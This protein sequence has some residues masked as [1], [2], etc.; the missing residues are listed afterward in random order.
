[1]KVSSARNIDYIV[2]YMIF[3]GALQIHFAKLMFRLR[4]GE[5]KVYHLRLVD[6][7]L[8]IVQAQ[9]KGAGQ[10]MALGALGI[11]SQCQLL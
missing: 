11:N 6:S 1:M 4:R 9:G 7:R 3:I 5:F 10:V 8:R 2:C